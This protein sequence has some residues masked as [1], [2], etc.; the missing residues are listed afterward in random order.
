MVKCCNEEALPRF[1]YITAQALRNHAEKVLKP[2]GLTLEQFVPLKH[3]FHE[4][5]VS[6]REICEGT[7]KTPANMTRILDRL[8]KKSLVE[9]RENPQDRR[10][11]LVFLTGKGEALVNEVSSLFESYSDEIAVGITEEEQHITRNVLK[12]MENNILKISE[13]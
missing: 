2:Y 9:R 12:K 1:I 6:Q 5:G 11:S 3:L 4:P 8:E 10:V 13:I 7:K